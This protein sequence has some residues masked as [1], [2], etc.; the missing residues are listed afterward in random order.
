MTDRLRRHLRGRD[1]Y[2]VGHGSFYLIPA[3][4][5]TQRRRLFFRVMRNNMWR[6][7]VV[8]FPDLVE[9]DALHHGKLRRSRF[10]MGSSPRGMG[11]IDRSCRRAGQHRNAGKSNQDR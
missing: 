6:F 8:Q 1:F 11:R 5:R 7:L 10:G 3:Q 2:F 4:D 9:W